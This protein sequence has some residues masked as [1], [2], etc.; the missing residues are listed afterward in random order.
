MR[1]QKQLEYKKV[2]GDIN[3]QEQQISPNK[4]L[5]NQQ[6]FLI[7]FMNNARKNFIKKC[8]QMIDSKTCTKIQML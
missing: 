8:Y 2:K 6:Q 1:Q 5:N 7:K 3:D 4:R